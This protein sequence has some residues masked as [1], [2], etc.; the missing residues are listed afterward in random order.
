[1]PFPVPELE[2]RPVHALPD[3]LASEAREDVIWNR[4]VFKAPP[5]VMRPPIIVLATAGFATLRPVSHLQ[6]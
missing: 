6:N 5:L 1:M 2:S 4:P 3:V